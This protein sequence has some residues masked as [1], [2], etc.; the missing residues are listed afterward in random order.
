MSEVMVNCPVCGTLLNVGDAAAGAV[1]PVCKTPLSIALTQPNSGL[2]LVCD[3]ATGK[4][5]A[6]ARIPRGWSAS[7]LISNSFQSANWPFSVGTQ[8]SSPDGR[9]VIFN[10][11]GASFRQIDRDMLNKRA[12]DSFDTIQMMPLRRFQRPDE[13]LDSIARDI[14]KSALDLKLVCQRALP[15]RETLDFSSKRQALLDESQSMLNAAGVAGGRAVVSDAFYDGCTR[16]YSYNQSG[17]DMRLALATII[18]GIEWSVRSGIS[19]VFAGSGVLG[20]SSGKGLLDVIRER[21]A[22]KKPDDEPFDEDRDSGGDFVDFTQSEQAQR[23]L[24]AHATSSAK[25]TFGTGN[26]RGITAYTDWTSHFLAGMIG[27]AESFEQNYGSF[28]DFITDFSFDD[29]LVAELDEA[30]ARITSEMEERQKSRLAAGAG[31]SWWQRT[32]EQD[33]AKK[34]IDSAFRELDPGEIPEA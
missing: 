3:A 14:L 4:P 27:P 24:E 2:A 15:S 10:N 17:A 21:D 28:I 11:S 32:Y 19:G 30:R 8:T 29:S 13:Y 31:K 6:R 22:A 5:A 16:I 18:D 34:K 7:A 33:A 26:N 12:D 1:C 9:T 23:A 20:T 25:K